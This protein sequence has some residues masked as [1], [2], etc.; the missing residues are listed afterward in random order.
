[1]IEVAEGDVVYGS[2]GTGCASCGCRRTSGSDGSKAGP[3]AIV[4]A[5]EQMAE[6]YAV[7][8]YKRSAAKPAFQ[9]DRLGS[10]VLIS[11]TDDGC[12]GHPKSDACTA[13]VTFFLS[14]FGRLPALQTVT[15]QKRAYAA[16]NEPGVSGQL[17]YV[18]TSSPEF[19][20]DGLKV[21][22]QVLTSD[23]SGRVLHKTELERTFVLH[24]ATLE[25]GPDSLW[26]RVYPGHAE[27]PPAA[28]A[29]PAR[30]SGK[31]H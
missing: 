29:P 5:F 20:V 11:A 22:E 8:V 18:L 26:A 1:M 23:S 30:A 28:P 10:E 9:M 25:G 4:R 6:V 16:G 27:A 17:E 7:G 21:Y 13:N 15:T 3:L 2:A 31:G 19:T 14:R 12:E 24:D